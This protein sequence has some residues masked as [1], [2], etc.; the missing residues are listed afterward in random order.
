MSFWNRFQ[1]SFARTRYSLKAE[2]LA[3]GL[4]EA[5]VSVGLLW[6]LQEWGPK[7][8]EKG[9]TFK[10]LHQPRALPCSRDDDGPEEL[11]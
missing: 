5:I 3:A 1:K 10:Q 6:C 7:P 4:V 8:L 11:H 2:N 9:K